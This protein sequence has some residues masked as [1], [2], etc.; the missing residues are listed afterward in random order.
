MLW[1]LS[2]LLCLGAART[3][4]AG[5]VAVSLPMDE[6]VRRALR[7]DPGV[8][9][10]AARAD[11]AARRVEPAGRPANPTLSAGVENV[12]GG[13]GDRVAE[14]TVSIEQPL[15]LGGAR[16]AR[17][18]IAA[19]EAALARI[20]AED[21]A[22]ESAERAALTYA[23]ACA[24]EARLARLR[25]ARLDAV[26]AVGAAAARHRAGGAPRSEV[27]R[28]EA[29]L[30]LRVVEL[31][32]AEA[33]RDRT[34]RRLH[35]MWGAAPDTT[36]TI[37]LPNSRPGPPPDSATVAAAI[38]AHPARR[39]AAACVELEDARVAAARAARTPELGVLA[40]VRRL[41][42]RGA[43]GF[44]LGVSAPIP[45]MNRDPGALAAAV[46]ERA[47]ARLAERAAILRLTT[48]AAEAA[49]RLSETEESLR[50][51]EMHA[52]PAAAA[53]YAATLEGYAAGRFGYLELAEAQRA[54]LE[55]DLAALDAAADRWR[56][57]ARLHRALGRAL[58]GTEER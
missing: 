24:A 7:F 52:R 58:A 25:R 13:L 40:G 43:T 8:A 10:A 26:D 45:W 30:A 20:E 5:P 54:L 28:A 41:A 47:A 53:A 1:L 34:R 37:A 55:T 4:G 51:L 17:R 39:L 35:A 32:R 56:A 16:G 33:E 19:G 38:E 57:L 50:L 12:G 23:D 49:A 15:D 11:A 22:L 44:L 18:A 2:M 29:A 48:E 36:E 46:A 42:E 9:A 14:T 3:A 6:A 31:R 27:H 21:A